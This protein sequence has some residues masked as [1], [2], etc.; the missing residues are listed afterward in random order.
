MKTVLGSL[1][2]LLLSAFVLTLGHGL[3]LLVMPLRG[4]LI[5]FSPVDIS[6]TGSA[7]Y[8]GFVAGCFSGPVLIARAGHVRMFAVF[9]AL[10]IV[11]L[12]ALHLSTSLAAWVL[13]RA[14]TGVLMAGQFMVIETW[15]NERATA[16]TRGRVLAIYVLVTLGANTLGQLLV[17]VAPVRS[18]VPFMLAAMLVAA[19]IVPIGLSAAALPAPLSQARVALG[20]L[21][22]MAP[23][24]F[25]G[26]TASGF[27]T[28]ASGAL[29]AVFARGVGFDV[30]AVSVYTS[31][32]IA[33]GAAFQ[34]P[35]G[36]LADRIDRRTALMGLF[37]GVVGVSLLAIA[38]T[39]RQ[40][41]W[42]P[43]IGFC[44]GGMAHCIYASALAH[45]N[46]RAPPGEIVG[47]GGAILVMWGIGAVI[48]PLGA[49]VLMD[50]FGAVGFFAW[51]IASGSV[52]LLLALGLRARTATAAA[53]A[54]S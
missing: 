52:A 40:P 49:S 7:Y 16:A 48:G 41:S 26:A 34:Y 30:F 53:A 28:G 17:N 37:T 19:S 29:N 22:R 18:E 9:G 5:G 14:A 13:L 25:V 8:A 10:L 44:W 33:G 46:D 50:V 11:A 35:I 3:A 31:A 1:A 15:L 36:R 21:W 23:V 54:G 27:I 45:A 4:E 2:A 47:I 42:L 39:L 6:L 24:A 51:M 38:V 12:L 43:V 20:L 32:V